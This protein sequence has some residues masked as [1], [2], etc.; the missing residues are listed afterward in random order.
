MNG[1]YYWTVTELLMVFK[2]VPLLALGNNKVPSRAKISTPFVRST[3]YPR[4]CRCSSH[5]SGLYFRVFSSLF[6]SLCAILGELISNVIMWLVL[7]LMMWASTLF[8]LTSWY[9]GFARQPSWMAGT[10]DYFSH[11]NKC[12]FQCKKISLS[13]HPIWLPC[14]TSIGHKP[15]H[16]SMHAP[17]HFRGVAW[18]LLGSSSTAQAWSVSGLVTVIVVVI[19]IIITVTIA[20]IIIFIY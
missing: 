8:A 20:V 10:I 15:E 7:W 3:L 14:K 11:G 1:Y 6:F 9:R 12:S 13:C 17:L 4:Y 18:V 5:L 19:S 2:Q 16:D